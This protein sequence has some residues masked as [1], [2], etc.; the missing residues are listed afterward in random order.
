MIS[1]RILLLAWLIPLLG[2]AQDQPELEAIYEEL[3]D[4]FQIENTSTNE[5]LHNELSHLIES[6]IPAIQLEV[7]LSKFIFLSQDDKT[8]IQVHIKE[9]G[10]IVSPFELN[11][12]QK[13]NSKKALLISKL[14]DYKKYRIGNDSPKFIWILAIKNNNWEISKSINQFLVRQKL[15]IHISPNLHVGVQSEND[16]QEMR[17]SNGNHFDF[18]SYYLSYTRN[19]FQLIVGD[20][21]VNYGQG[22]LSWTGWS[23]YKN[24]GLSQI[25]KLSDRFRPY[26]SFDENKFYRGLSMQGQNKRM[27]YFAF[28]SNKKVDA[29]LGQFEGR[30]IILSLP[31]SG[32]HI[33]QSERSARKAISEKAY[34]VG[35]H[36][37]FRN[38]NFS[39]YTTKWEYPHPIQLDGNHYEKGIIKTGLYW[40]FAKEGSSIFQEISLPKSLNPTT[41]IGIQQQ[42]HSKS[43]LSLLYKYIHPNYLPLKADY[44]SDLGFKP[45]QSIYLSIDLMKSKQ[46]AKIYLEQSRS[47]LENDWGY[48]DQK[49]ELG[50]QIQT[51]LQHKGLLTFLIKREQ[52]REN[53]PGIQQS[54]QTS[55]YYHLSVKSMFQIRARL[56]WN[57]DLQVKLG[58][59]NGWIYGSRINFNIKGWKLKSGWGFF[60]QN[61]DAFYLYESDISGI[62]S[63]HGHFN[64]GQFLYF[65]FLKKINLHHVN[66]KIYVQQ[67]DQIWNEK[68]SIGVKLKL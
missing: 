61:S 31:K 68:I 38:W 14:L 3:L 40:S 29:K 45:G 7:N 19:P 22:L 41:I 66:F 24:I 9:Y 55:S 53:L 52:Q 1:V 16:P 18:N 21:H 49:I 60:N 50:F 11:A 51:K 15:S 39:T 43:Y 65:Q 17:F 20:F 62:S 5:Q 46:K 44:F 12:I 36:Y 59:R 33:S 63:F 35:L 10:T 57:Q 48:Q 23:S 32:L 37:Q 47:S 6:P 27:S 54:Y 30:P 64:S 67:S 4:Q 8:A 34:S 28:Y 25:K 26:R 42:I 56:K 13:I 58:D 2:M